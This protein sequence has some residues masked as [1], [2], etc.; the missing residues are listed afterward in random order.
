VE[1]Y[2]LYVVSDVSSSPC[3]FII[4]ARNSEEAL[5]R[6]I[7]ERNCPITK[8]RQSN[9]KVQ[10]LRVDGYEISVTRKA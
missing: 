7:E 1:T 6:C 3:W 8:E 10:E 4:P 5:L 9:C 2:R